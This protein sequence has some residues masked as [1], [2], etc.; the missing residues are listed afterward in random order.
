MRPSSILRSF[1]PKSFNTTSLSASMAS[2]LLFATL[3]FTCA[4]TKFAISAWSRS[5]GGSAAATGRYCC[6]S[7]R[8]LR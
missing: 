6:S 8:P 3:T 1:G 4:S 5:A 2:I 7:S